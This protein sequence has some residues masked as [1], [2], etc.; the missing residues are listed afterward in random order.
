MYSAS[1][2]F[3]LGFDQLLKDDSQDEAAIAGDGP[4][5]WTSI[6]SRVCI[7]G[8]FRLVVITHSPLSFLCGDWLCRIERGS[9]DPRI[10]VN[11]FI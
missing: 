8:F 3:Y 7:L 9:P 2:P 6:A 4:V 1:W 10:S 11:S 5:S